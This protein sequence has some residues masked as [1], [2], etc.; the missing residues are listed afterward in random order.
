M[1]IAKTKFQTLAICNH[2]VD[3][4]RWSRDRAISAATHQLTIGR[5]QL[6]QFHAIDRDGLAGNVEMRSQLHCRSRNAIRYLYLTI[7]DGISLHLVASK[8]H[9]SNSSF[10]IIVK[11]TRRAIRTLINSQAILAV[12]IIGIWFTSIESLYY[13]IT[14]F[15][16][17]RIGEV[18][19]RRIAGNFPVSW[20]WY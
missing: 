6:Q 1:Q 17:L 8:G 19:E 16:A 20:R 12:N 7:R 15:L 10:L 9:L 5:E 14:I 11:E 3:A 2:N 18:T 4:G 13:L